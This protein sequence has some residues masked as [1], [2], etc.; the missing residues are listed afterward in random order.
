MKRVGHLIVALL[1][2]MGFFNLSYAQ[3]QNQPKDNPKKDV[4][5]E[6]DSLLPHRDIQDIPVPYSMKLDKD[7]TFIFET[8]GIK[9]GIISYKG[10]VD[11]YSLAEALKNNL[12]EE[13]WTLQNILNYKNTSSLSFIKDQRNLIIFIEE[14]L[15]NTRL[16]LR[17]GLINQ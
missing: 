16:E 1:I 5:A 12:V 11:G 8:K 4:K 13:K 17:V 15:F 10:R 6:E 9:V 3:Q 7:N 2:V 14:G